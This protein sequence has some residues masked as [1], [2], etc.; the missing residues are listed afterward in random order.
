MKK[1]FI[2]LG[3]LF[4]LPLLFLSCS[5]SSHLNSL[6]FLHARFLQARSQSAEAVALL[7]PLT[8]EPVLAPWAH[9][10]LGIIYLHWGESAAA[11]RA[12]IEAANLIEEKDWKRDRALHQLLFSAH[13]NKAL[14]LYM[15]RA[16]SEAAIG[17]RHALEVDETSR[18]AKRNLELALEEILSAATRAQTRAQVQ[19]GEKKID[20][21]KVLLDLLRKGEEARW[22]S[23]RW[24][25]EV[26]DWP[27]Y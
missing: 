3:F 7:L 10:E 12:F 25:G 6:V 27:D 18:A 1:T 8:E 26:G 20:G 11:R 22:E 9:Y 19:T 21:E 23:S 13:Y 15:E 24:E 4:L 16:F 2:R 5:K 14:S 17:F